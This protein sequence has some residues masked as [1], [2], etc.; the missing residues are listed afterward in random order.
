MRS[1]IGAYL[2]A[3]LHQHFSK[4]SKANR[5]KKLLF[6]FQLDGTILAPTNHNIWGADLSTWLQFKNLKGLTI[7]GQG[8]IEGQGSTW[9]NSASEAYDNPVKPQ[10]NHASNFIG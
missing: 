6:F 7:Q 8:T 5:L 10:K 2:K 9:W 3:L 1:Y 4:S